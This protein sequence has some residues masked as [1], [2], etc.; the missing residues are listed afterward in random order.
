MVSR[1]ALWQTLAG[2]AG[3]PCAPAAFAQA[4]T[5]P[6]KK[7]TAASVQIIPVSFKNEHV[8]ATVN[9]EKILVGEVKKILDQ[10]PYPVTLTEEQKKQLRQAAVDVLVEDV[11]MRQYLTKHVPQVSQAEFA[12][13]VETLH[14]ELKEQIKTMP[15]FLQQTG[16]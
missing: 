5:P 10:R 11:L 16:Q 15:E 6:E 2:T 12:K 1:Q 9:G 7:G 13:E 4:T 8:A 3:I 14:A